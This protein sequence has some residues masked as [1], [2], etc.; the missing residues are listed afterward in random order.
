MVCALRLYLFVTTRFAHWIIVYNFEQE[1]DAKCVETK[2]CHSYHVNSVV[3]HWEQIF[4]DESYFNYQLTHST[5]LAS[6]NR[7]KH[8]KSICDD[9]NFFKIS[10]ATR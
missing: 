4:P 7:L 6:D 8:L 10:V 5:A 3:F 2:K 9:S 1:T